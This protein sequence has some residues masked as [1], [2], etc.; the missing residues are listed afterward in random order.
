MAGT[1][2]AMQEPQAGSGMGMAPVIALT[3]NVQVEMAVLPLP[4]VMM[5]MRVQLQ[6][7]G[8]ADRKGANHQQRHT[9]KP[10]SPGRHGLQMGQILDQQ[11]HQ[12]QQHHARCMT[13]PPGQTRSQR[14]H[15]TVQGHRG[16]GHQVIG[17]TDDM[18]RSGGKPRQQT[19][20]HRASSPTINCAGALRLN[21]RSVFEAQPRHPADA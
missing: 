1:G 13:N 3:A 14:L 12:G 16:H 10:F 17:S 18:Q 5:L 19:D 15:R 20:Q 9:H 6:S 2:Q 4:V 8:C 11:C 21:R 7:K